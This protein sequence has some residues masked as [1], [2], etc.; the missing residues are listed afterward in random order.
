MRVRT[1][2]AIASAACVLALTAGAGAQLT[3]TDQTRTPDASASSGVIEPPPPGCE[4]EYHDEAPGFGPYGSEL[5]ADCSLGYGGASHTSMLH[6]D[7]ISATGSAYAHGGWGAGNWGNG[8][9]AS[10]F[11]VSFESQYAQ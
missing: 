10:V 6:P 7:D 5:V 11:E 3:L 8:P 2:F 1:G 4:L 9:G